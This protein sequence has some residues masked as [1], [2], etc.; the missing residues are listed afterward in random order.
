MSTNTQPKCL[1]IIPGT[2]YFP[3]PPEWQ[4]EPPSPA[5]AN[6]PW[7]DLAS[8]LKV[9]SA[10]F[11]DT[12]G[13][14][15]SGANWKSRGNIASVTATTSRESNMEEVT[16]LILKGE[17][18]WSEFLNVWT[19]H[20]K[21]FQQAQREYEAAEN[22]YRQKSAGS[23][24]GTTTVSHEDTVLLA[25]RANRARAN[26][27]A[28]SRALESADVTATAKFKQ[29]RDRL[30]AL[31]DELAQKQNKWLFQG[32]TANELRILPNL[33][34]NKF[35]SDE[36]LLA[37]FKAGEIDQYKIEGRLLK[38]AEEAARLLAIPV[39]KLTSAEV[40]QLR[41][42]GALSQSSI[43]S[44]ALLLGLG[45]S[46]IAQLLKNTG[47]FMKRDSSQAIQSLLAGSMHTAAAS[48]PSLF[49]RSFFS[50]IISVGSRGQIQSDVVAGPFSR[51]FAA[52]VKQMPKE[53]PAAAHVACL[54]FDGLAAQH[55]RVSSVA[56]RN[57]VG[58]TWPG[59]SVLM[60]VAMSRLSPDQMRKILAPNGMH[61]PTGQT[62]SHR[63]EDAATKHPRLTFATSM[64]HS[65]F[66]QNT[67]YNVLATASMSNQAMTAQQKSLATKIASFTWS[68]AAGQIRESGSMTASLRRPLGLIAENHRLSVYQG[69]ATKTHGRGITSQFTHQAMH[70][71]EGHEIACFSPVDTEK[72]MREILRDE[73]I[74]KRIH[75]SQMELM[76]D[77][78]RLTVDTRSNSEQLAEVFSNNTVVGGKMARY[79]DEQISETPQ[80]AQDMAKFSSHAS[81]VAAT[82][83]GAFNAP[84][85]AFGAGILIGNAVADYLIWS[86]MEEHEDVLRQVAVQKQ[87]K[88]ST[89]YV[90][91]SNASEAVIE[92]LAMIDTGP[93]QE[94][95]RKLQAEYAQSPNTERPE[96][97][98]DEIDPGTK[99]KTGRMVVDPDKITTPSDQS[100]FRNLI[101]TSN[102]WE[103]EMPRGWNI[104]ERLQ[105][106]RK[107]QFTENHSM[108]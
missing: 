18:A 66:L 8:A 60:A 91:H 30:G 3:N 52:V 25:A 13:D 29:V 96:F 54:I 37:I 62:H 23:G 24:L 46:N 74:A 26:A 75:A 72:L 50:E 68:R 101:L 106:F 5:N 9:W 93:G 38:F 103:T 12:I 51:A 83:A 76:V 71:Y 61:E 107:P 81:A 88:E 6:V 80:R 95:M 64:K 92:T 82:A 99:K 31:A 47:H 43:F 77:R 55:T 4:R 57:G 15:S 94:V 42:L 56:Q 36:M 85:V 27:L 11:R 100:K 70:P 84:G 40:E 7:L 98:V 21:R 22:E 87:L 35:M 20:G 97:F 59:S 63:D 10:K 78:V 34:I 41:K 53:S 79:M 39:T 33:G 1:G 89:S 69:L 65:P 108:K 44:R 19:L 105:K 102:H 86:P 32:F 28:A 49:G 2:E 104:D 73:R 14:L 90:Q 16:E 58:L 45:T 17:E 48:M 67:L